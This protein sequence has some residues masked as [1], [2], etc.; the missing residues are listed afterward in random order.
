[1]RKS[2]LI[3]DTIFEWLRNDFEWKRAGKRDAETVVEVAFASEIMLSFPQQHMAKL[4]SLINVVILEP[5]KTFKPNNQTIA[6]QFHRFTSINGKQSNIK[7]AE[8]KMFLL[9]LH[10]VLV[11]TSLKIGNVLVLHHAQHLLYDL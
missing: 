6:M 5:V 3:C 9:F 2:I 4:K 10:L 8:Q 7:T 1:M 11:Q